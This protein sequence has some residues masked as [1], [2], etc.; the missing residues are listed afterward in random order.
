M[1]VRPTEA[2]S[3]AL[4]RQISLHNIDNLQQGNQGSA[5]SAG[6]FNIKAVYNHWGHPALRQWVEYL[7]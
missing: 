1:S 6:V 5:I 2:V 7:L 4:F 3:D